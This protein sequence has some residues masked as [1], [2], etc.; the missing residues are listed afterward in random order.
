[1]SRQGPTSSLELLSPTV[2]AVWGAF[3]EE[4]GSSLSWEH[5]FS[6]DNF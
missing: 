4:V 5:H 2:I 3:D 6:R 1:M